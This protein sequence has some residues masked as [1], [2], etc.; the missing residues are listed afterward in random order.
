MPNPLPAQPDADTP[1]TGEQLAALQGIRPVASVEE[2]QADIWESDAE[3]DEFIEDV[4]RAR[5]ANVA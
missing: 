2:M 3:V 1:L 4:R 5:R